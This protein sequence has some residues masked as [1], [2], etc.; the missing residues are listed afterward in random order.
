MGCWISL[1]ASLGAFG[2]V[3]IGVRLGEGIFFKQSFEE[4]DFGLKR[5]FETND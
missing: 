2:D 3:A 5:L 1:C 4:F